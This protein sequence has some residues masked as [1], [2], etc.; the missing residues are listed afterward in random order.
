MVHFLLN[1]ISFPVFS[2]LESNIPHTVGHHSDF[3]QKLKVH[4]HS[5]LHAYLKVE[6]HTVPTSHYKAFYSTYDQSF[7]ILKFWIRLIESTLIE[8]INFGYI[9]RFLT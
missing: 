8:F 9:P 6:V 2:K 4:I 7:S 5:F 1:S 3:Y